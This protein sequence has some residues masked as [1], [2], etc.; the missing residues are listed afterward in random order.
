MPIDTMHLDKMHRTTFERQSV[1]YLRHVHKIEILADNAFLNYN[2]EFALSN[3]TELKNKKVY[4]SMKRKNYRV[5]KSSM[6]R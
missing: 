1:E 2:E 6:L 4:T 3:R 5:S